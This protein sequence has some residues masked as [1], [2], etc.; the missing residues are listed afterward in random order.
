MFNDRPID[1]PLGALKLKEAAKYLAMSP[2]SVRR[3][4]QRGLINP[5]R[6]LRHIIIPVSELNRFLREGQQRRRWV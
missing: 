3:L 5:N 6:A 4:I 2:M 1:A